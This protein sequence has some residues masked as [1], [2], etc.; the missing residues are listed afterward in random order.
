MN[1]KWSGRAQK[2]RY[3][4]NLKIVEKYENMEIADPHQTLYIPHGFDVFGF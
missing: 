4:K 3:T 1:K 2:M